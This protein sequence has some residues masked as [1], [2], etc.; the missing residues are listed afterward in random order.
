[1]SILRRLF[2]VLLFFLATLFLLVAGV[3]KT[4]DALAGSPP[5]A[6]AT[7]SAVM[8]SEL[9][10]QA[11]A[12]FFLGKLENGADAPVAAAIS[13]KRQ[14][15]VPRVA[16][17]LREPTLQNQIRADIVTLLAAVQK[18]SSATVDIRPI[19]WQLTGAMHAVDARVPAQP[20]MDKSVIDVNGKHASPLGLLG[21]L[22]FVTWILFGLG[23]ALAVLSVRL[24]FKGVVK[25]LVAL[26]IAIFLPVLTLLIAGHV[27]PTPSVSDTN[28]RALVD[29]L[30]NKVTGSMAG[31][32]I[33]TLLF[34]VIVGVGV[35][36]FDQRRLRRAEGNPPE[37]D[38]KRAN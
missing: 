5:Q 4:V 17:V 20:K 16:A 26:G 23:L 13:E 8:S 30:K 21:A 24:F 31:T 37:G 12:T 1:M 9:G 10:S 11:V 29:Q 15:L 14:L 28:A 3:T 32:A 22:G 34:G 18:G 6:A 25:Q 33:M 19:L 36:V 38:A 7:V 35:W 27:I 2:A